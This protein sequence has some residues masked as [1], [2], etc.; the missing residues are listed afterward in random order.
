MRIYHACGNAECGEEYPTDTLDR[1]WVCPH[2]DRELPNPFYPFL[3]A[4]L[5]NA[6]IHADETDW[7]EMHAELLADA[8]RRAG[9]LRERIGDLRKDLQTLKVRLPEDVHD[10]VRDLEGLANVDSFL[11]GWEPSAPEDDMKAWR[12]L[13]D[14]LLEGARHEIIALEDVVRDMEGNIRDLKSRYSL[15]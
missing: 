6:R 9:G 15:A 7:Q 11:E 10:E 2:C 8:N 14:Q 3:T 13:Y 5:M 1:L 4:R 12:D